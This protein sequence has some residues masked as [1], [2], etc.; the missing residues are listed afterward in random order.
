MP[1]EVEPIADDELLYRRVPASASTGWFDPVSRVLRPEAFGPH[2]QRDVTGISVTR[3][4]YKPIAEAARGQPGK[5]YFVAVLCVGDLRQAN[6]VVK[7]QPNV[8]GGY[9]ISHAELPDLNAANYKA[10]ET[11]ERQRELAERLCLR[12]EGPFQDGAAVTP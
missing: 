9:D 12:V 2:R 1:D 3:A 10:S 4:R 5:S 7:P 11:L 6:Y 8:P